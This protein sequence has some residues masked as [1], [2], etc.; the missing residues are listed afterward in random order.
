MS[1]QLQQFLTT[2]RKT[3]LGLILSILFAYIAVCGLFMFPLFLAEEAIQTTIFST[4]PAQDVGQ[5]R[6]VAAGCTL[7]ENINRSLKIINYSVGW[8]NPLSFVSYRAY[9]QAT[10]QYI[11]ALRSKVAFHAP[12]MLVGKW[13]C[14]MV[15]VQRI[16]PLEDSGYRIKTNNLNILVDSIPR[17]SRESRWTVWFRSGTGRPWWI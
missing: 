1:L 10:D 11:S 8:I 14:L 6:T 9:G 5:W 4:W 7:M 16:E 3:K 17:T 13:I 12:E 15:Q 2:S